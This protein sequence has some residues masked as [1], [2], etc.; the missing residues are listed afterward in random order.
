[1]SRVGIVDGQTI[2]PSG[3]QFRFSVRDVWD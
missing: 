1:M 3:G 2:E